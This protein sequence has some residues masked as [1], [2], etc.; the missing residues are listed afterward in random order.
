MEPKTIIAANWKMNLALDEAVI[1]ARD[2]EKYVEENKVQNEVVLCPTFMQLP[3]VKDEV[4]KV[5]LGAQDVYYEDNGAFTGEISTEMLKEIQTSYVIVGHSERRHVLGETDE[6]VNKKNKKV[7]D[8]GMKSI[9]CVGETE[10]QREN[11]ETDDVLITQVVAG[12][13]GA[14]PEQM[15]DVVI[16][17]EPVWAIGTGNNATLED[18][19]AAIKTI[20]KTIAEKYSVETAQELSVLYGGSVKPDNIDDF[21]NSDEINGVLVGGASLKKDD[22]I[23]LIQAF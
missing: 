9:F 4:V 10:E 3:L 21:A 6:I 18:A 7:L 14:T 5:I 16:A 22:F 23:Q 17:Y 20:R 12:L 11:G 8:S 13:E 19:E 1:L 2:I 15:K